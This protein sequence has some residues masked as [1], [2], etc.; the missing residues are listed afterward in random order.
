MAACT[1]LMHVGHGV[2]VKRQLSRLI[3]S[4]EQ[5]LQA[6]RFIDRAKE[7]I[8][9]QRPY[10]IKHVEDSDKAEFDATFARVANLTDE[11]SK[12]IPWLVALS[13]VQVRAHLAQLIYKICVLQ[14]QRQY[15]RNAATQHMNYL[16]SLP[17]LRDMHQL[18]EQSLRSADHVLSG[19]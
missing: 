4:T 5:L 12:V 8:F 11:I 14:E 10:P 17:E 13:Q 3:N 9:S 19:Q 2:V 18:L 1:W 6:K 7:H 16:F 15:Y